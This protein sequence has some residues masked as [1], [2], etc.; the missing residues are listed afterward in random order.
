MIYTNG[1]PIATRIVAALPTGKRTDFLT[2]CFLGV[3]RELSGV[4]VEAQH[5][6]KQR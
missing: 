3:Y 1:L 2:Q 4:H 5:N 6:E